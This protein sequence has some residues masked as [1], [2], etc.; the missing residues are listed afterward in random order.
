MRE[1]VFYVSK[2][3][4]D[5]LK[6]REEMDEL[7]AKFVRRLFKKGNRKYKVMLPLKC[8]NY[9]RIGHFASTLR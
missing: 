5:E 7:E 8:F 1:V 4:E 9:G 2:N 3:P 6:A